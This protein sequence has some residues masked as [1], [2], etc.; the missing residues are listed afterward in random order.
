MQLASKSGFLSETFIQSTNFIIL[1]NN[2]I[3]MMITIA[4]VVAVIAL[5]ICVGVY[6]QCNRRYNQ[7]RNKIREMRKVKEFYNGVLKPYNHPTHLPQ[8]TPTESQ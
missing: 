4:L 6:V 1:D 8:Q 2:Q 5:G 7:Q 3:V